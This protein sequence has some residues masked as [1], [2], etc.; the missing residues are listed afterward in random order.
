MICLLGSSSL[1]VNIPK[2]R[3][4]RGGCTNVPP[5]T[6]QHYSVSFQLITVYQ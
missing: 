1:H 2:I 3:F 4:M 5:I 6:L